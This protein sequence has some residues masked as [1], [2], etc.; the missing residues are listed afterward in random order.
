MTIVLNFY[1]LAAFMCLMG[2]VG[3]A[4][5]ATVCDESDDFRPVEFLMF[6]T[7]SITAFGFAAGGISIHTS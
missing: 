6:A 4:W 7:L 2:A 1:A 3:W 5:A